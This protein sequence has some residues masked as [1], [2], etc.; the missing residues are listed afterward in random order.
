MPNYQIVPNLNIE[1][2]ARPLLWEEFWELG[3]A[4]LQTIN[5]INELNKQNNLESQL[6]A[7]EKLRVLREQSL[8]LAVRDFDKIKSNLSVKDI[9]IIEE[10]INALSKPELELGNSEPTTGGLLM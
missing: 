5:D 3:K 2:F 8:K 9:L 6:A 10:F 7:H 1:A 4:R